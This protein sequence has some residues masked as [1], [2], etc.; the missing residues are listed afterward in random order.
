MYTIAH[1]YKIYY[2]CFTKYTYFRGDVCLCV[3]FSRYL[4]LLVE[5]EAARR[6]GKTCSIDLSLAVYIVSVRV[7]N[8]G[9]L[10]A[11]YSSLDRFTDSEVKKK[12]TQ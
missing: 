5:V 3:Y 12:S 6:R 11:Q 9:G 2:H 4:L 8:C 10:E 1:K 7:V